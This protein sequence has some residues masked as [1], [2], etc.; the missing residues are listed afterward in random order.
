MGRPMSAAFATRREAEIVVEHLVQE[1]GLPPD[2]VEIIPASPQNSTGVEPS[3]SDYDGKR[4]KASPKIGAEL[5]V[6]A[7]VDAVHE[8]AVASS[9]AAYGGRPIG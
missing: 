2:A 7:R 5:V 3:G 1:H 4:Q 6:V 8:K 9:F